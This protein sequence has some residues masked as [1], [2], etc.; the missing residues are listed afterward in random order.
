[1]EREK[2]IIK[3]S[4]YGIV[5]NILLVIF[6]T[7]I[8]LISNSIAI[9]LDAVNN[10]S[11]S[12]SAII[13][14]IGTKLSTKRPDAEHPFGHGRIEYISSI[15]I[16]MIVMLA[17]FA[18]LKESAEKIINP[19]EAV[20]SV[21]TIMII[22]VAIAV[23]FFFGRYVKG[24]GKSLNSQNLIATGV[25][26]YMD[27]VL[28]FSTLIAALFNIFLHL[29]LEGYIGAFISIFIIK[30]SYDMLVETLGNIIGSRP[31]SEI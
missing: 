31:D 26:A 5:L 12:L 21:W 18:S 22:V 7:V 3:T 25:D 20:Y 27:A 30:S 13:T 19:V 17:G 4:I 29:S 1:M 6:K 23:K 16:V 28:S 2:K 9:I 11:D 14:I 8:G 24:V 15:I 10:L